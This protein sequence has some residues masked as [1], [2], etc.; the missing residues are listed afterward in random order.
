VERALAGLFVGLLGTYA[1]GE[2]IGGVT[3]DAGVFA[4]HVAVVV[5]VLLPTA[6]LVDGGR[7]RLSDPAD[8]AAGRGRSRVALV[9]SPSLA[10]TVAG[11]AVAAVG[12]PGGV[13]R[14]PFGL[15]T[16][17]TLL[18]CAPVLAGR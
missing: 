17:G 7:R 13:V 8:G 4:V 1:L 16:A 2:V 9:A 12:A 10:A 6:V 14:L 5:G 11:T 18:L 3:A 15:G